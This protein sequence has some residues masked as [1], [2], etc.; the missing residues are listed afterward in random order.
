MLM[1]VVGITLAAVGYIVVM[2][3]TG[4]CPACETIL[5]TVVP[6]SASVS[7]VNLQPSE[8]K[9]SNG[10]LQPL[11]DV[12]LG[13][14]DGKTTT[15]KQFA[16][17]PILIEVWATWCGPCIKARKILKEN[18]AEFLEVA[19]L[20]GVS[21]DKGGAAKVR[22]HLQKNPMPGMHEFMAS[23]EFLK[24][25]APY[26]QKRTIPKFVYVAPDGRIIDIAYGVPNPKFATS[27]LRNLQSRP[28]VDG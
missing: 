27:L 13:T 18:S 14:L 26:D 8:I 19:T 10:Q 28:I 24:I 9:E 12:P 17:K 5:N 15:L 21:V 23:P 22:A 16:G 6:S 4:A 7:K 25:I 2:G 1:S 11:L 20:V 3:S